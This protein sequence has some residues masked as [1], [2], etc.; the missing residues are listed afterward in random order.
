VP[1]Q[2]KSNNDVGFNVGLG[3]NLTTAVGT[4]VEVRYHH[5]PSETATTKL[6]PITFGLR[7]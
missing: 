5:I 2:T 1:S 6:V 7:F 4:F 3:M